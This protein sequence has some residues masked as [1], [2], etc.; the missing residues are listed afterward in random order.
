LAAWA[1]LTGILLLVPLSAMQVTDEVDWTVFDFALV[2]ALLLAAGAIFE[3]A[4]R[5]QGG[6]AYRV[7]AG[8]AILATLMLIWITG[9]VGII[10]TEDNDANMMYGAVL[11]V[12]VVGAIIAR[13]RPEGMS[14][15][16]AATAGVQG[17][18]AAIALSA[19]AGS[20]DPNWP[21]DIVGATGMFMAMWLTS[22]WLFWRAA[23]RRA[24]G[25]KDGED[26]ACGRAWRRPRR[27]TGASAR[28]AAKSPCDYSLSL[29]N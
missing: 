20:E 22:A 9:A 13:F 27:R 17:I 18:I 15:A 23:Q 3:L 29:E 1:A 24:A 28:G 26:D 10:G 21:L 6:A 19:R 8:L 5:M 11:A 16:M 14:R 12:A 7:G 25:H 4:M 2:A